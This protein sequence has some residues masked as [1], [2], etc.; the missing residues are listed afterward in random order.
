MDV[1]DMF[2]PYPVHVQ[3]EADLAIVPAREVTKNL[4]EHVA[5]YR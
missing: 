4:S 3:W 2:P 5:Q 1:S